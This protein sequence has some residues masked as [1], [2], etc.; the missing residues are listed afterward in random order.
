MELL[1]GSGEDLPDSDAHRDVLRVHALQIA[2]RGQ[3][4]DDGPQIR[5]LRNVRG[6]RGLIQRNEVGA[7]KQPDCP[8]SSS[9]GLHSPDALRVRLRRARRQREGKKHGK[10]SHGANIRPLVP[11][12]K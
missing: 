8:A 6:Y 2:A 3:L 11:G 10:L 1:R 9:A 5:L 12:G 4:R 7:S